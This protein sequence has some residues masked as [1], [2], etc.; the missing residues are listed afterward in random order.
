MRTKAKSIPSLILIILTFFLS[1]I[2]LQARY[3][4]GQ[5]GSGAVIMPGRLEVQFETDVDPDKLSLSIDRVS[6]GIPTLDKTLENIE[7]Y[8]MNKMFSGRKS[9]KSD[10]SYVN[11]SK[12]YE[13]VFPEERDLNAVIEELLQ[14]PY[15]R[16]VDPVYAIPV[17]GLIP[18]DPDFNEQWGVKKIQDTLAWERE[19]GS[20]T[21]KIA[22]IDSGV[23][24][25]HVDLIDN[26]WV[27]PGEDLDGDRVV[28][29]VD[30]SNMV[31]D[32]GNGYDDLI[33]YDFF[34]GFSG[35][36]CMDVDCGI[37][38]NNPS[39]FDGHGT[40]V[41]GIAAAVT[42]NGVGVAGVAGGWG[43]GIG[44]YAGPRI[45]CLRV[46]GY[47]YTPEVG[48]T[49]Y[50][51]SANVATA[52]DYAVDAGACVM[53]CSFGM[54]QS[55]AMTAALRRADSAGIMVIHAAGNDGADSPDYYDQWE[56]PFGAGRKLVLVVAWTNTD[57]RKN[58]YS[59]YG[60]WVDLCA[61]GTNIYNTYSSSGSQTYAYLSG[62]SM[63]APHVA[64][65]VALIKSH[66][67]DYGRDEIEPLIVD[68]T[69]DM[70]S[71]PLWIQGKLGSGRLNTFKALEN[72]PAAAFSA[73]PVLLG[74]APLTVDFVDESPNSPTTWNWDFGDGGNSTD[75]NPNHTYYD[76]GLK[77]VSLTVD[78]PNG[79]AT[80]V[81]KNLVMVTADTLRFEP[82]STQPNTE[83]VIP[84]YLDNKYL[85]SSI[86][87]PFKI[88]RPDGSIPSYPS[89]IRFDSASTVGL[90]TENWDQVKAIYFDPY[91]QRFTYS[92]L[93]NTTTPGSNYLQPD[94]GAILNLYFHIGTS[95]GNETLIIED[96][97]LSGREMKLG[98]IYSDYV[99]VMVPGQLTV[100]ICDRGDA[101]FSG[102][103]NILDVTYIINYLYKGGPEP[104]LYCADANATGM[105]NI[106]DVTYIINYLYK[107]GP[108]PPP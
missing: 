74:E 86:M 58:T 84:V 57:D 18:D 94:T 97:V 76:Y 95:P 89:Y 46:G 67:P 52:V 107:G 36:T 63:A 64:G 103:I 70:M 100:A 85:V 78:E 33:G 1:A 72:L 35:A 13:I 56:D 71:E 23:L 8:Q 41:A 9:N 10:D 50:V 6:F 32:D 65:A 31:D 83:V 38:D 96:T 16:T 43:G 26:I 82:I 90:R 42:N 102:S 54:T 28:H 30:D 40:H 25:S 73:G 12:F 39:D 2:P 91:G 69:D 37:P 7:V 4:D 17:R 98:S 80:E 27:N 105:I 108:P 104:D 53:N 20:D 106:L 15:V 68:N 24:F 45:M 3:I 19:K 51:N 14:N 81:L 101:D 11:M 92:L 48:Y 44:P 21:A 61:P 22:I 49:G 66:M 55:T 75:Q 77:T 79:T 29:D 60:T 87:L 47:G 93:P 34:T 5:S 62:T 59:N 99:P 88:R